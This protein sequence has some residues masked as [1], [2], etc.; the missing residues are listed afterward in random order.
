MEIAR[1]LIEAGANKDLRRTEDGS[2]PLHVA[3]EEGHL[4]LVR[5]LIESGADS[6]ITTDNLTTALLLAS[7]QGHA[8]VV[9][10]L[11]DEIGK[12]KTASQNQLHTR[13]C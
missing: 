6:E 12:V 5:L 9:T 2:T 10:F 1:L 7:G 8:E 3:A 4:D 13:W 11:A